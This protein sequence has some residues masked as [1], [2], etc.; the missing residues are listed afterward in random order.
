MHGVTRA[1]EGEGGRPAGGP[2]SAG[3]FVVANSQ[4]GGLV[5]QSPNS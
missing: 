3:R 5:R 4:E 1:R 2:F